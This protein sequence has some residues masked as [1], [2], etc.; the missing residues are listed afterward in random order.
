MKN[1]EIKEMNGRTRPRFRFLFWGLVLILTAV[2]LV[3]DGL[4][5]SFGSTVTVW[6]IIAGILAVAWLIC[7]IVKFRFTNVFFPLAFLFIIFEGTIAAAIGRPG[8]NLISNWIVLLAALLLTIAF[9]FISR[10]KH[11]VSVNGKQYSIGDGGKIGSQTVYLDG[12]DLSG[13]VITEHLGTTKVYISNK[14]AYT[15]GGR[16]TVRENLG[17]VTIFVPSEWKV[18]SRSTDNLGRVF[19]PARDKEG[20]I[21][22]ELEVLDNIG[23]V[24]VVFE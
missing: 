1:T 19:I 15:G 2:I 10:P 21:P 8:E 14:E 16:I 17:S 9:K 18:V 11:V 12:S 22:L 7:E 5:V 20:D 24:S 3:M 23:S 13:A 6:H 4:G